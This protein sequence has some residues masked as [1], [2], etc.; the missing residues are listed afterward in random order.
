M[1]ELTNSLTTGQDISF[2]GAGA[3][4]PVGV[5]HSL[6]PTARESMTV[7]LSEQKQ[8][9]LAVTGETL[10]LLMSSNDQDLTRLAA[11]HELG[12]TTVADPVLMDLIE[13]GRVS[14]LDRRLGADGLSRAMEFR[15]EQDRVREVVEENRTLGETTG[16]SILGFGAGAIDMAS[17]IAGLALTT[18]SPIN[19][20]GVANTVNE[21]LL[22]FGNRDIAEGILTAGN[23]AS[24]WLRGNESRELQDQQDLGEVRADL[25]STRINDIYEQEIANGESGVWAS[26]KRVGREILSGLTEFYD[27]PVLLGDAIAEAAPS[28]VPMAAAGRIGLGQKA[29]QALIGVLEGGGQYAQIQNEIQNLSEED[30]MGSSQYVA[31]RNAGMNHADAQDALADRASLQGATMAF[32]LGAVSGGLVAK[33]EMNPIAAIR[34]TLSEGLERGILP[35]VG[36]AV[37]GAATEAVEEGIQEGGSTLINNFVMRE[38]V[39]PDR[40][41]L[42]GLGQGIAAGIAVGSGL[43]GVVSTP[44]I[45]GEALGS[46]AEQIGRLGTG[47]AAAAQRRMETIGAQADA[48]SATGAVASEAASTALGEDFQ[49]VGAAAE[50]AAVKAQEAAAEAVVSGASTEEVAAA[51][52]AAEDAAGFAQRVNAARNMPA[53]EANTLTEEV[54]ALFL[55][56]GEKLDEAVDRSIVIN[57]VIKEL[58]SKTRTAEE[59]AASNLWL[60]TQA[61]NLSEILEE[62]SSRLSEEDASSFASMRNNINTLLGNKHTKAAVEAASTMT[63]A[64]LGPM[65]TITDANASSPEVQVAVS[66]M[67]QLARVNPAGIDVDMANIIL[68]QKGIANLTSDDRTALSAAVVIVEA[69]KSSDEAKAKVPGKTNGTDVVRAQIY[70]LG[71]NEKYEQKGIQQHHKEIVRN[72]KM[73]NKAEAQRLLD[74]FFNF[75]VHMQNKNAAAKASA[76]MGLNSNNTVKFDTWTGKTWL[77]RSQEAASGIYINMNSVGGRKLASD[78]EIDAATVTNAYKKLAEQYGKNNGLVGK[79][80]PDVDLTLISG[81][82]PATQK[83][84]TKSNEVVTDGTD[85]TGQE[86]QGNPSGGDQESSNQESEEQAPAAGQEGNGDPGSELGEAG[87][88]Q[89]DPAGTPGEGALHPNDTGPLTTENEGKVRKITTSIMQH[90]GMPEWLE[91]RVTLR[92][93]EKPLEVDPSKKSYAFAAIVDRKPHIFLSQ[94]ALDDLAK[95]PE[96]TWNTQQMLMHEMG[97]LIDM[98]MNTTAP[99]GMLLTDGREWDLDGP[100]IS[101]LNEAMKTDTKLEKF[102]TRYSMSKTL[103]DSFTRME[104]FA[105][106]FGMLM[107][108]S[109]YMGETLPTTLAI[110]KTMMLENFDVTIKESKYEA[111]YGEGIPGEAG[112]GQENGSEPGSTGIREEGNA[113]TVGR[114]G[115]D[116]YAKL[117]QEPGGLNR[118]LRAFKINPEKSKLMASASPIAAVLEYLGKPS[119]NITELQT[120]QWKAL[121]TQAMDAV[122]G[123]MNRRLALYRPNIQHE[124]KSLSALQAVKLSV[125]GVKN[126]LGF[127]DFKQLALVEIQTDDAGNVTGEYNKQL[128]ES[129]VIAGVHWVMTA[130]STQ[131]LDD[132]EIA[133]NLGIDV[134]NITPEI[135]KKINAG[136]STLLAK[137]SLALTIREFWGAEADNSVT[138]SDIRGIS[139]N[140]AAEMLNAMEKDNLL[141]ER[142]SFEVKRKRT[143]KEADTYLEK[144]R[145]RAVENG[146]EF[147]LTPKSEEVIYRDDPYYNFNLRTP[148]VKNIAGV[149]TGTKDLM[150]T[151]FLPEFVRIWNFG[152]PPASG[153][154][155]QKGNPLSRLGRKMLDALKT[156][157]ETPYKRNN[158]FAQLT[159]AMGKASWMKLQGWEA[160]DE[161][162]QNVVDIEALQGKNNS[163]ENSWEYMQEYSAKLAAYANENGVDPDEVPLFFPMYASKNE[164]QMM[165][166]PNV[167]A[168]KDLRELV[169][170]TRSVLD[171][172]DPDSKHSQ[173]FWL[174]IAQALGVKTEKKNRAINIV[175]AKAR[176]E[177]HREVID[178]LKAWLKN[179]S[180]PLDQNAIDSLMATR[181][182][183]RLE[184][185]GTAKKLHAFLSVAQFELAS[186][187][188]ALE[189]YTHNL[190]LEADGKTDGPINAMVHFFNGRFTKKQLRLMRKGGFFLGKENM[191]LNEYGN[192]DGRDLYMETT[193]EANAE[194]EKLH[195]DIFENGEKPAKETLEAMQT[196]M[197]IFGG[198]EISPDGDLIMTR[199]MLKNPVTITGYGSG[200]KGMASN[201]TN[202][203]L[204]QFYMALTAVAADRVDNTDPNSFF[205][206]ESSSRISKEDGLEIEK[207]MRILTSQ[208]IVFNKKKKTYYAVYETVDQVKPNA[209]GN[210]RDV[211][212]FRLSG[213]QF[214]MLRD[215]MQ[216]LYAQPMRTAIE[217]FMGETMDNLTLIQQATQIM[218]L[219]MIDKFDAAVKEM[220][221]EKRAS[222]ELGSGDFLS[223]NDYEK[224]YREVSKFGAIIEPIDTDEN[225]LNLSTKETGKGTQEFSRDLSGKYGGFSSIGAPKVAGVSAMPQI[226]ISR[227]DAQMMVNFFASKEAKANGANRTVPVFD[228]LE[229]PADGIETLSKLI[230]KAVAEGWE[231]NPMQDAADSFADWI[232][233]GKDG[234]L[235]GVT[236][237]TLKTIAEMVGEKMTPSQG[238]VALSH[239]MLDVAREIQARKNAI[240]RTTYSVDHMASGETPYG[241]VGTEVPRKRDTLESFLN[242][243]YREELKKI[244]VTW[245]DPKLMSARKVK[246][247][248][249]A[250][251]ANDRDLA[252]ALKELGE[253]SLMKGFTKGKVTQLRTDTVMELLEGWA[254]NPSQASLIS[255]LKKAMP[256]FGFVI[257]KPEDLTAWRDMLYPHKESLDPIELGQMDYINK[258]IY[259]TNVSGETILHEVL[260]AALTGVL[261]SHYSKQ[262]SPTTTLQ[263]EAI[264]NLEKLMA[265]FMDMNFDNELPGTVVAARILQSE[266]RKIAGNAK[267]SFGTIAEKPTVAD[268][269]A[270]VGALSE[271]IS[272]TLTN[273]NLETVLTKSKVK[274]RLTVLKDAVLAGLKKLLGM[275][276]N[277]PMDVFSNI[278]W[279]TAA[280]LRSIEE[281]RPGMENS[282][283]ANLVLNQINPLGSVGMMSDRMQ[284]IRNGFETKVGIRLRSL[285]P[286]ESRVINKNAQVRSMQALNTFSS[287]GFKFTPDE[288]STFQIMQEA[289]SVSAAMSGAALSQSQKTFDILLETLSPDDFMVDPNDPAEPRQPAE[290]MFDALVGKR[291]TQRDRQGRS[292]L[293]VSALALATVN[294]AFRNVLIKKGMPAQIKQSWASPDEFLESLGDKMLNKLSHAITRNQLAGD[295]SVLEAMDSLVDV[296]ARVEQDERT[297]VERKSNEWIEGAETK[298]KGVLSGVADRLDQFGNGNY[299]AKLGHHADVGLRG[300]AKIVAT[301]LDA[302]RAGE[303]GETVLRLSNT[304]LSAVWVT[305]VRNLIK[306]FVG[307]TPDTKTML[308]LLNQAKA[309]ISRS[310]QELRNKVPE[311]LKGYFSRDITAVESTAMHQVIGKLSLSTLSETMT[312][313]QV[314]NVLQ[315][316]KTLSQSRA[317]ALAEVKRLGSS[318]GVN[319]MVRKSDDLAEFMVSGSIATN[320]Y[321][322]LKNQHAIANLAGLPGAAQ[323]KKDGG[324]SAALV[325]AIATYVTLTALEKSQA[326]EPQTWLA[327]EAIMATDMQAMKDM[328]DTVADA[329]REEVKRQMR[330]PMAIANGI[331]G[332]IPSEKDPGTDFRVAPDSET[333]DLLAQGYTKVDRYNG[334]GLEQDKH[335]YFYSTVGGGSPYLEGALQIVHMTA[336][337]V[338]VMSGSNKMGIMGGAIR[339]QEAERIRRELRKPANKSLMG[340]EPLVPLFNGNWEFIGYERSLDPT[341][342]NR[343]LKRNT[344]LGEML[345]AWLGRHQEEL[346]AET[347][348]EALI[349]NLKKSY[350]KD[351]QAGTTKDYVN[352]SDP[353]LKDAIY[354]ENWELIPQHTKDYIEQVFDGDPGFMIR[355]DQI[356]NVVGYRMPTVLEAWGASS[357]RMHKETQAAIRTVSTLVL[358]RNA[359]RHLET[360]LRNWQSVISTTKNTI[361]VRSIIVAM[362]N[363]QSNV[364]QMVS[365]GVGPRAIIS[366]AGSAFVQI[367][368]YLENLDKAV[369]IRLLLAKNRNNR[370]ETIKLEAKLKA[371]DDSNRRMSIWPLI[372]AGEFSTISDGQNEVD[373]AVREG[374]WADYIKNIGEKLP[375]PVLTTAKYAFV[376]QDTALY[377]GLD[378]AIKYGDFL[379]KA[380]VYEHMIKKQNKSQNE[381]LDEIREEFVAYNFLPG[382]ARSFAESIGLTWFWAFKIRSVKVALNSIRR[383]PLKM[384]MTYSGANLLNELPGIDVSSPFGDNIISVAVEGRLPYSMGLDMLFAAPD[385]NPF[386]NLTNG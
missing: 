71:K 314:I 6:A 277:L 227:G 183:V 250:V 365:M 84:I 40:E 275:Q 95:G 315:D 20:F 243:L 311:I 39:D 11:A 105:E 22:G 319:L 90:N 72:L 306:E 220:V 312:T 16:D 31:F 301:F 219:V 146:T 325:Q 385:M 195:L 327:M 179:P 238:I 185:L 62:G 115:P 160:I 85:S 155:T 246:A 353:S 12:H 150:G 380:I 329:H 138:M 44:G 103:D 76:A 237:E 291:G 19:G 229:M 178:V 64:D 256:D 171:L 223:P 98:Q 367:N 198:L 124:K 53:E 358:G 340:G 153:R 13:R 274:S 156:Q 375:S 360:G 80:L 379:S 197:R 372:E 254:I 318:Y 93:G 376:A 167:Q 282:A 48:E 330:S 210:M 42:P 158:A 278:K 143:E 225:S 35:A 259:V 386:V 249:K 169:V 363:I 189:S 247:L 284:R 129:A 110:M 9:E 177:K 172:R 232:R 170:A 14:E 364:A 204:E 111:G 133:R 73:G 351:L 242:R 272:W 2:G 134:A 184:R 154:K 34:G 29:G 269:H 142:T 202:A 323:I 130:P 308:K 168:N 252:K 221:A 194:V 47:V 382:R 187:A 55:D 322:F 374:K 328:I 231:A 261:L 165:E 144:M 359:A 349:D 54:R 38:N 307:Q 298:V 270:R 28:L 182:D 89:G 46:T 10:R 214:Q 181:S 273:Q 336:M 335:S 234:L 245:G 33:L 276:P 260:H 362:G 377:K 244:P 352:L 293:M 265:Q 296:L 310:R 92:K 356:E 304:M 255:A 343:A 251:E 18:P 266:I 337:G 75:A 222:G 5:V 157:E 107:R 211:L 378:R 77:R 186:E 236:P 116:I 24:E 263:K 109:R 52:T 341:I 45:A 121:L 354:R 334:S 66:K 114:A 366:G 196:L 320:N 299:Q 51:Q 152:T 100:V 131:N 302:R 56:A 316:A 122:G 280:L 309:E 159:Q 23:R 350:D 50:G 216:Q 63:T 74:N 43:T 132:E 120:E 281:G 283:V 37:M 113:A 333:Q 361:V 102:M 292:N 369:K 383:A 203:M 208:R 108:N 338:D 191:T 32:V 60:A 141:I 190:S 101:E 239:H 112:S 217:V 4:A 373:N 86:G 173:F 262:G 207:A 41:I 370:L 117:P 81:I 205:D 224:V 305:P 192:D 300:G 27:N 1:V 174:T 30:L 355:L 70:K 297:I 206:E 218:S 271:F 106:L 83:Q 69:A 136:I 59:T 257:G 7:S 188:G 212:N 342:T 15:A 324:A 65:P 87:G 119:G 258:V 241:H 215:N 164:R 118:F 248:P 381:A 8:A 58:A 26:T 347:W 233:Q 287:V 240:A 209:M 67:A 371:I 140:L 25:E 104:V 267:G 135:R 139:E 384:L 295:S 317:K 199:A 279:N 200:V 161:Q 17:G 79:E 96:G 128:L 332:F 68:N 344:D 331:M 264:G 193:I 368:Q 176:V 162:R 313:D 346:L 94:S 226:T 228:G 357:T 163:L 268:V 57:E 145:E 88:D 348:N 285:N 289:F 3:N 286:V 151:A 49:A 166:G 147:T 99:D 21:Q 253:P 290:D 180:E 213:S 91:K 294:E 126:F 97:H 288:A 235:A 125:D 201:I 149:L 339:G 137:E 82:L 78:V 127:R 326:A 36:R 61:T 148:T 345:G 303:L 321:S 230:N 123:E 175:E